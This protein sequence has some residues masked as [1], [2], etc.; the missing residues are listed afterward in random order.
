MSRSRSSSRASPRVGGV[1]T[2]RHDGGVSR[3]EGLIPG[4]VS[5][6]V[7]EH[8]TTTTAGQSGRGRLSGRPLAGGDSPQIAWLNLA[9]TRR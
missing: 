3:V 1:R 6:G 4:R 7:S 2:H 9:Y 5:V 8:T